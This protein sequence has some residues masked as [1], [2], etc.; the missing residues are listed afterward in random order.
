MLEADQR[1][2]GPARVDRCI[3]RGDWGQVA[4]EDQQANTWSPAHG[5]RLLSADR[6]GD[7]IT[8]WAITDRDRSATMIR[9]PDAYTTQTA[10]AA[11]LGGFI[12]IIGMFPPIY[13]A[14]SH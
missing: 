4:A 1:P 11:A 8:V 3:A 13:C 7:G 2:D 9:I 10:V 6:V 14:C 12:V 5:E